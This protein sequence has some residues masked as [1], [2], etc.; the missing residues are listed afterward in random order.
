M[1][2]LPFRV[3]QILTE[4]TDCDHALPMGELLRLLRIEYGLRCDRRAVYAALDKLRTI[5]RSTRVMA[6]AIGCC[7]TPWSCRRSG[8]CRTPRPPFRASPNVNASDYWKNCSGA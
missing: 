7:P 4:H 5:F 6:R 2:L 1:S 8:C 3:Y